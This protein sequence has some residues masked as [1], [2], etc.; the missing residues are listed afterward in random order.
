MNRL[1]GFLGITLLSVGC[2]RGPMVSS[3]QLPLRRVVVYRNGVGYFERAGQVDESEVTFRMRQ[4]A[5]GDFLATLA[6]VERG[7][8]TVRSASFPIEVEDKYEPLAPAPCPD[9]APSEKSKEPP[10]RKEKNPLRR[11]SLRL[12]GSQHDLAVG[13]VAETPVW[14]PS[15]R[16][17]IN[18]G[19]KAELQS[20][21]IVEN[22]S[23]EDWR[24]VDL[25]LVAGAPLA[26]QSTLGSPITPQRPVVS[27]SGEVIAAMPEAVTSLEKSEQSEVNRYVPEEQAP[28]SAPPAPM[29]ES[30]AGA[31]DARSAPAGAGAAKSKVAPK[32]ARGGA[33]KDQD[34]RVNATPS[35]PARGAFAAQLV[36]PS[37]AQA[38]T[39]PRNVSI[40]A[41]VAVESGAT[42]YSVPYPITVPDE[43]ATMVLL[44]SQSV[45]GESVFLFSQ[46]PGVTDS[47]QHPFRVARF[48]NS[49]N[50]LLERGP[51]AVF[52]KGSFLGQGLLDSLPPGATA[53]VPF[54]LERGLAVAISVRYD[55]R[56]ARLFK[57]ENSQ[58]FV[59]RDSVTMTTYKIS[60][61]LKEPAK[62]LV[63]HPRRPGTRL[64]RP[65]P[66]TEDNAAQG[67][68]LVPI[69]TPAS[70][71][72]E[73]VV[74]ERA[75]QER[76]V[77]WL[78]PLADEAVKAYLSDNRSDA[79]TVAKLGAAWK[80]RSLW[81]GQ[82]DEQS[83]LATER[84]EL[85]RNL[86]QL[87]DSLRAIEKNAQAADL[88]QKL[89]RKL[90][91]ASTRID[92]IA[93]RL[94]EVEVGMRE[95]EVRF[96]DAMDDV[97]ILSVPPP[98]E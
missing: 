47:S 94:V 66:G 44:A 15:Y 31:M 85:E 79:Q 8:S 19:G 24:D 3:A 29:A 72:S 13:Y 17:V 43:S 55:E 33:A 6:I 91:E 88:R 39:P 83:K 5:V 41:G 12:D 26:F 16:V 49:T 48:K 35:E 76:V 42:R 45:P 1:F 68:A 27:D 56:G 2:G 21:G 62:V 73:L 57:I 69:A 90:G 61:G 97:K 11:V 65:A 86:E 93:K 63:R 75:A 20:W 78:E 84:T 50:G 64:F 10:E 92:Q 46:D 74:D 32:P 60:N 52:E 25:V 77:G 98:R 23:G 28:P 9:K 87:K 54:A 67:N 22:L 58:I 82:V 38:P 34:R 96:R 89:T 51:I 37:Q 40:L 71:R 18:E 36:A 4:H 30:I 80:I 7:G 95:Q 53:T 81:K 14:R 59:E 70:G